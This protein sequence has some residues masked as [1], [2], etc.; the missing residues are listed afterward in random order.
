MYWHSLLVSFVVRF[1]VCLIYSACFSLYMMRFNSVIVI[2]DKRIWMNVNGL[3]INSPICAIWRFLVINRSTLPCSSD[4]PICSVAFV[5]IN[6]LLSVPPHNI[7]TAARRFSVAAP[8]LWNYLPLSCRTAPSVNIFKNR[9][10]W[11]GG[12]WPL[13]T[14]ISS[15][16][17]II[18]NLV[19]VGQA[20][21][22]YVGS[23]KFADAR[24]P[25]V[26]TCAWMTP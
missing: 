2:I 17:I 11:V 19:A 15:T 25:P 14:R 4:P 7:D 16:R 22:V 23:Q 24:A 26:E 12:G 10:L 5:T 13:E 18:P 9:P 20:V 3:T 8:R 21:W 6:S 1:L